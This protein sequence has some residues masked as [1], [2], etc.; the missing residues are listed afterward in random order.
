[1]TRL[2]STGHRGLKADAAVALPN[3]AA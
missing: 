2:Q 3:R 1:M